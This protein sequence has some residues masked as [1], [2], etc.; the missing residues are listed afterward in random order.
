MRGWLSQRRLVVFNIFQVHVYL[1]P[2][3]EVDNLWLSGGLHLG[4]TPELQ[5]ETRAG[6]TGSWTFTFL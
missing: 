1:T 4:H 6:D 3:Y 2:A 5:M